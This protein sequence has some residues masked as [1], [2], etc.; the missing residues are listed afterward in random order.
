M[1]QLRNRIRPTNMHL[2]DGNQT[3]RWLKFHDRGTFFYCQLGR[4]IQL[5]I[6]HSNSFLNVGCSVLLEFKPLCPNQK[7]ISCAGLGNSY[8]IQTAWRVRPDCIAW[9]FTHSIFTYFHCDCYSAR[10]QSLH[11]D[12][13]RHMPDPVF[14]I[15]A[16]TKR[17]ILPAMPAWSLP[18]HISSLDHKEF[19]HSVISDA[20]WFC[21]AWKPTYFCSLLLQLLLTHCWWLNQSSWW[22]N[23]FLVFSHQRCWVK[24]V[25]DHH[26]FCAYRVYPQGLI[27]NLTNLL[28]ELDWFHIS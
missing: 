2:W 7:K 4:S 10:S 28:I 19:E 5:I 1:I 27:N 22:F 12:T 26:A 23:R 11:G 14:E 8:A 16:I 3:W 6:D 17:I 21:F 24:M 20:F 18:K 15:I 9:R 25:N 13:M